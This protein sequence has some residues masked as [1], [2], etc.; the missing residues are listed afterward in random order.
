ME[1]AKSINLKK[2]KSL[3]NNQMNAFLNCYAWFALKLREGKSEILIWFEGKLGPV[4][5]TRL[6]KPRRCDFLLQCRGIVSR[7]QFRLRTMGLTLLCVISQ[8]NTTQTGLA[9][10]NRRQWKTDSESSACVLQK[11]GTWMETRPRSGG[12]GIKIEARCGVES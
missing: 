1:I 12:G 7:A 6:E 5:S 8:N 10:P 9:A 2:E 11:K 3:N 4:A